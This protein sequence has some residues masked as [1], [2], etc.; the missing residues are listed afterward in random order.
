M[1]TRIRFAI[2]VMGILMLGGCATTP[3]TPDERTPVLKY[4]TV[5]VIAVAIVDNRPYVTNGSKDDNFEGIGRTGY[6]IPTDFVKQRDDS[7]TT[8]VTRVSDLVVR[9]LE[10]S[11]SR[12]I[13]VPSPK[14]SYPKEAI[15]SLHRASAS[16]GLIVNVLDSRIDAGGFR[17]SYFFNYQ[18]LVLDPS[19]TVISDRTF[20]GED[21]DFQRDIFHAASAAG[22]TYSFPSILD[23]E[24]KNKFSEF[25]SEPDT[26][27]ALAGSTHGTSDA[28]NHVVGSGVDRLV[29]LKSMLDQ[30]LIS[31]DDYEK[32]KAEILKSL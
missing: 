4:K 22:K 27:S 19:G 1:K 10:K 32:K 25:L 20:S 30:G 12:V 7:K 2:Y 18:L 21:V 8:Y 5:G 17:W 9:A 3:T 14:G 15:A 13:Y 26:A 28:A 11:G 23:M 16:T 24:Y 29:A 31:N 6:G